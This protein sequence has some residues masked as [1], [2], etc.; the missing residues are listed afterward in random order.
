LSARSH[1]F[2][3]TFGLPLSYGTA[4]ALWTHNAQF[5]VESLVERRWV[6]AATQ[7]GNTGQGGKVQPFDF[8]NRAAVPRVEASCLGATRAAPLDVL[9][10]SKGGNERNLSLRGARECDPPTGSFQER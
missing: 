10:Q 6:I 2:T 3:C 1:Y 5:G 4:N 7:R 8:S 9:P